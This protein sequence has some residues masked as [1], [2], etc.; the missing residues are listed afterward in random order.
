MTQLRNGLLDQPHLL[1]NPADGLAILDPLDR[2]FLELGGVFL[3]RD[4]LSSS[5]KCDVKFTSPLE[6]EIS[7]EAQLRAE[8]LRLRREL[9][10]IKKAAAYF[11]KDAL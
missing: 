3:L 2:L 6:D 9:E 5:S 11:A 10:I 1:A 7:G 4:L 8:N